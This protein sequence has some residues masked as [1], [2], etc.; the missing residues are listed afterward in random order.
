MFD[1]IIKNAT[2]I[3]GSGAPKQRG[4]LAVSGDRIARVGGVIKR[5]ATEV[6]DGE[7]LVL[8]P[9][10]IDIHTHSDR[11]LMNLPEAESRILQGITTE[12]GGN[13]GSCPLLSR[14]TAAATGSPSWSSLEEYFLALE[15]K[16]ISVN[17]GTYVGH[18]SVR[19]AVVGHERRLATP[20]EINSMKLLVDEAMQQGA[21]GIS[22]GLIYPP[23]S[24][25][26]LNELIEVAKAIA[27]YHGIFE[28]HLRS[29]DGTQMMT[30]LSEAYA[31]GKGAKVPVQIAHLKFFGRPS[32]G[33][34]VHAALASLEKAQADGVD[35]TCDQYPYTASSSGLSTLVQQWAHDGGKAKLVERLQNPETRARIRAEILEFIADN[36]AEWSDYLLVKFPSGNNARFEGKTLQEIAAILGKEPVDT[37]IDLLV[38]EKGDIT[39][40][41]FSIGEEDIEQIM[42][43][44]LVMIGSDGN[45]DNVGTPG[46]AHPRSFGAFARVLGHYCRDRGVLPIETAIH[47]MTGFPSWRLR[48]PD[49]GL[50]RPGFRADLVLFDPQRI[51]DVATYTQPKQGSIGISRVYVN[52]VL[53]AKDDKHTGAKAG[54]IIRRS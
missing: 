18:G 14:S 12:I 21:F 6:I 48:L 49:R 54:A 24:F 43:H 31:V 13:C 39:R 40:I 35:I 5:D 22:T 3:D 11:T 30:S 19:T 53:T 10:F 32:W 7:G 47:K 42:K 38:E 20:D 45:T 23:S 26:D 44:R 51:S 17:F 46:I 16:G 50:L 9:G 15:Q 25:A 28:T 33:V 2:L 1:L 8:S 4:D 27:P 34:T 29:E 36:E 41:L 37:A 52:G